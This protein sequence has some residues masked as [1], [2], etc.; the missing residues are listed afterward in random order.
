MA[1]AAPW[2]QV[3]SPA[4]GSER[5]ASPGATS[6]GASSDLPLSCCS[7]TDASWLHMRTVRVG[8]FARRGV[9]RARRNYFH[10]TQPI[11]AVT[12]TTMPKAMR[13]QANTAKL[14]VEM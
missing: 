8:L 10:S 9:G 3:L 6:T 5:T 13:Y 1:A 14:W 4:S 2:P 12:S 7:I 11:D